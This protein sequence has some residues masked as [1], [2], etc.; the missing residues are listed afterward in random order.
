MRFLKV[1]CI[2][3]A[4]SMGTGAVPGGVGV[5]GTK[6]VGQQ[7]VTTSR[8]FERDPSSLVPVSSQPINGTIAEAAASQGLGAGP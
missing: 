1:F 7:Q 4:L 5:N 6:G 8:Q 2:R 3:L